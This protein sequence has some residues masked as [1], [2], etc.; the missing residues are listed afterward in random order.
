MA[1]CRCRV[2]G[3]QQK[4]HPPLQAKSAL[5]A[6]FKPSSISRPG[7]STRSVGAFFVSGRRLSRASASKTVSLD[8]GGELG[9]ARFRSHAALALSA[10]PC[11]VRRRAWP[12]RDP[13]RPAC[14]TARPRA[15]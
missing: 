1:R 9:C 3:L 15:S 4:S 7:R 10:R 14:R 11:R 12:R 13:R 6:L 2:G 5:I 8:P